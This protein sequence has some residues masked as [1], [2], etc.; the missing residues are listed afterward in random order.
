VGQ[1]DGKVVIVTGSAQGMGRNHV[2]RCVA[3]GAHVVAT[4]IQPIPGDEAIHAAQLD[5]AKE[6]DWDAVIGATLERFGR[7][8][9]LV[10]NAAYQSPPSPLEFQGLE[11]LRTTLEVNV[12][13]TWWGIKKVLAPMRDNGGGSIVNI[14]STAGIRG[15]ASLS[16]YCTSKWAVRGLTKSAAV[17]LG[18]H[19]IRVNSVHPGPIEATGMFP[20]SATEDEETARLSRIPLHRFGTVDD[21][22]AVVVFLL[23]DASSYVTGVEHV[24]DGGIAI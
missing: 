3:E 4:D 13:G 1:L 11:H 18:A 12:V 6:D 14:S 2:R 19:R 23:S 8:D 16:S 21:V 20:V 10:N 17:E 22:S 15:Y 9:G 7:I 5:V 24:V